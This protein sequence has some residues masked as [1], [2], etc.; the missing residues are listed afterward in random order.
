MEATNENRRLQPHPLSNDENCHLSLVIPV[1]N[2]REN[3]NLLHQRIHHALSES[4]KPYEIIYIDDGSTDGSLEILKK[5]A[6]DDPCTTVIQFRRNFGQTA[7]ISAGIDHSRGNVIV[8][9]D[10]DLQNDPADIPA[11]LEKLHE[12]YDLVSGWRKDR[13]DNWFDRKIP[14]FLAN[15]MISLTLGLRLRDYGCTLKACRRE[16]LANIRLYGQMHRFIPI[17]VKLAGGKIIEIP[18]N[19]LPRTSGKSKYGLSRTFRVILDLLTVKFL[20]SFSGSPIYIFGGSGLALIGLSSVSALAMIIHKVCYGISFV[21]TPFLLLTAFLFVLGFQSIFMG[22]LAELL[23]RTYHE[24]Q[25]KPT[26]V[27]REIF[28]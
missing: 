19:H 13:K 2:E 5:I 3:L 14:S 23:I 6:I 28:N 22:L 1:Y 20:S 9:L 17:Y 27:V 11:M 12:G 16:L 25:G 8:F 4:A 18:V 26:Y 7:A 10:S 15:W 21:Q 24:S